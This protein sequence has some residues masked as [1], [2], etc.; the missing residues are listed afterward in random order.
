MNTVLG[1]LA[2]RA[3]SGSSKPRREAPPV[4][5]RPHWL[6]CSVRFKRAL[7]ALYWLFFIVVPWV[8]VGALNASTTKSRRRDMHEINL[9]ASSQYATILFISLWMASI[10]IETRR[11]DELEQLCGFHTAPPAP[12]HS[13]GAAPISRSTEISSASAA[14]VC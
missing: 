13:C 9:H 14:T 10:A 1:V 2:D 5:Q 12:Q 11:A 8:G 6:Q 3:I 7:T 4:Q